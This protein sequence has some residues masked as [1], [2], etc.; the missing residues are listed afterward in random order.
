MKKLLALLLSVIF[1]FS[2][3]GCGKS[4]AAKE[5]DELILSIKG[6]TLTDD[7]QIRAAEKAVET[8]DKEDYEQLENL[9]ALHQIRYQY[10]AIVIDEEIKKIGKV[11]LASSPQI[12]A[13][14]IKYNR[15]SEEVKAYIT[16]YDDLVKAE[17]EYEKLKSAETKKKEEEER[18]KKEEEKRKQEAAAKELA[19][20]KEKGKKAL[21]NMRVDEDKV[22]KNTFYLP[23]AMPKY[24]NSRSYVLPYVGHS[25]SSTWL[26][27]VY[28]YTGDSWI[29]WQDLKISVD[30]KLYTK[31]FNYFDIVRDNAYGDVWEYIDCEVND[32]DIDLLSKIANSKETI[33]RFEGKNYNYDLTISEKDKKAI[34][35]VLAV[36]AYLK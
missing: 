14:R 3:S 24:T 11:T 34:D 13:A 12:S 36:Y 17:K 5:A 21:D 31:S 33:V 18:R 32:N 8:L 28:H 25:G 6:F 16:R 29:F 15:A 23:N 4:K 19:A 35:D 7:S 10:D 27:L 2:L 20:L 1:I 26:R 22:L 9:D 30:G